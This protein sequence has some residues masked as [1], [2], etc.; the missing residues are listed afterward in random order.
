MPIGAIAAV[1]SVV[2]GIAQGRAAKSAA[3]AQTAAADRELELQTRIYDETSANFA[4]Y[5]QG[6]QLGF[7]AYLAEMGLGDRP[8]VGGTVDDAGVRTGGREFG[9]FQ[10]S[11]GYQFQLSRGMD[12]LNS[13]GAARGN[14]LSGA[15]IAG[16]MEFGQGL[17]NQ[18]Y[19]NYLNRLQGI[20][21]QGQAAAG[22]QAAAGVEYAKGA[23]SSIATM[24]YYY[25]Y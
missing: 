4:P 2:G 23:G 7:D 1:G 12:A 19:G 16:A 20:G 10:Q 17:A 8:M 22:N 15:N 5:R 21:Q 24:N 13:S 25:Y 9:G 14:Y 6:G 18:D 11:P 3:N